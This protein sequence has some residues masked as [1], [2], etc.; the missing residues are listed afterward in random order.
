M[1]DGAE[2]ACVKGGVIGAGVWVGICSQRALGLGV[3]HAISSL[4]SSAGRRVPEC[5][6]DPCPERG[7]G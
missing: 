1:T 2:A 7:L 5:G 6:R 4:P 3:S